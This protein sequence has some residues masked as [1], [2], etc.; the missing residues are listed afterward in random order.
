M[1]FILPNLI[2][3]VSKIYQKNQLDED[4]KECTDEANVHPRW[5]TKKNLKINKGT[6]VIFYT[7]LFI[8][9][10]YAQG[11]SNKG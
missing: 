10:Q 9:K 8:D 11:L 5:T 6:A 1:Y 7:L 2:P 4:K 3:C